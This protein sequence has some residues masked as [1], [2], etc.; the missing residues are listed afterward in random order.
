MDRRISS[1]RR[2]CFQGQKEGLEAEY[3]ADVK[4]LQAKIGELVTERG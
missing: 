1:S 2:R 4:R 3:R